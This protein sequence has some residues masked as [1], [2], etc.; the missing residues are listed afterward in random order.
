MRVR[1]VVALLACTA[2][3]GSVW[4][5]DRAVF[6]IGLQPESDTV[7]LGSKIPMSIVLTN[8][9]DHDIT[10]SQE[11]G[12]RGE[13]DY[14]LTVKDVNVVS[15]AEQQYFQAVKGTNR[16]QPGKPTLI[17]TYSWGNHV[18][19]PGDALTDSIDLN[20]LYKLS[21]GTYTVHAERDDGGNGVIKSNF[22]SVTITSS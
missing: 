15:P 4:S 7:R 19:K 5:Q 8:V 11:N 20:E 9:S 13:F 3:V 17:V 2:L 1:L 14:H 16:S 22:A 21:P 10:I 6:A 12:R 18:L